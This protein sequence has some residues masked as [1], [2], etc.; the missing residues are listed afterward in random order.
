MPRTMNTVRLLF[1][2]PLAG[3]KKICN[4]NV[5]RLQCLIYVAGKRLFFDE[6]TRLM[7]DMSAESGHRSLFLSVDDWP[8]SSIFECTV[9]RDESKSL[10]G[11]IKFK[12]GPSNLSWLSSVRL[13]PHD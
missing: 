13:S 1:M 11:A 3:V 10:I 2:P 9:H 7:Q 8:L 4:V 6:G 5:S 12:D